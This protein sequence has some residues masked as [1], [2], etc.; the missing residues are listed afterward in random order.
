MG[1]ACGRDFFA[2][3]LKTYGEIFIKWV[4]GQKSKI[5]ITEKVAESKKMVADKIAQVKTTSK[6]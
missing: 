5:F 2:Y 4:A 1:A 6:T 3:L